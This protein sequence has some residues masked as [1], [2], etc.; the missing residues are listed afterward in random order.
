LIRP[1]AG[2]DGGFWEW[3]TMDLTD[4]TLY[5]DRMLYGQMKPERLSEVIKRDFGDNYR[6]ELSRE[7][8]C[9]IYGVGGQVAIVSRQVCTGPMR[10]RTVPGNAYHFTIKGNLAQGPE[11]RCELISCAPGFRYDMDW[12]E[13]EYVLSTRLN[14]AAVDHERRKQL[15]KLPRAG[16]TVTP[17]G[18]AERRNLTGL[19]DSFVS[20]NGYA[21]SKRALECWI[22]VFLCDILTITQE[23][24]ASHDAPA[25]MSEIEYFIHENIDAEFSVGD[26]VAKFSLSDRKLHYWFKKQFG[27]APAAYLRKLKFGR[28][29][30]ELRQAAARKITVSETAAR[31]GFFEMSHFARHY[32]A[33]YGELPSETLLSHA[34]SD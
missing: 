4:R 33:L 2:V 30:D 20:R 28:V 26:I 11:E 3:E 16:M 1:S 6:M 21:Y 19:I 24:W 23:D 17:I 7:E 12:P 9:P 18:P 8:A 31:W 29:R 22:G 34:S 15:L 25:F 13:G 14:E 10:T 5:A 32:R 27:V